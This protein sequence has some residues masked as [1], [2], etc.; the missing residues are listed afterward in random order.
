MDG[1]GAYEERRAA[2]PCSY[3]QGRTGNTKLGGTWEG[4][5]EPEED[6]P[7]REDD[8]TLEQAPRKVVEFPSLEIVKT[9]LDAYP[10]YLL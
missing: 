3:K 9:H 2:G 4:R 8:S 10:C 5:Y 1:G 6:L 7:C